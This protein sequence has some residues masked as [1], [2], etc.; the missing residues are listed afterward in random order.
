MCRTK[1]VPAAAA[2][3]LAAEDIPETT[4]TTTKA[5]SH[6]GRT[7]ITSQGNV[8]SATRR[9][10]LSLKVYM[11]VIP[12][13]TE[14]RMTLTP[15]TIMLRRAAASECA[16]YIVKRRPGSAIG[17]NVST[18]SKPSTPPTPRDLTPRNEK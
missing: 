6:G 18:T 7:F 13:T 12:I 3:P 9:F 14:K 8:S 11:P 2:F 15:E 1:K 17:F 4:A 5:A 16:Q 10:G